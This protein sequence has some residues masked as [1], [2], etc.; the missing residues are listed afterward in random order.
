MILGLNVV[1][2]LVVGLEQVLITLL[3]SLVV[4]VKAIIV[5]PSVDRL[6]IL[7]NWLRGFLDV[8]KV[9]V[10]PYSL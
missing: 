10:C 6:L 7:F 4:P 1:L 8:F 3:M 9:D 2:A 5:R